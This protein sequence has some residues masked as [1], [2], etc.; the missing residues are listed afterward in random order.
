MG[1]VFVHGGKIAKRLIFVSKSDFEVAL[2]A[3]LFIGRVVDRVFRLLSHR[4]ARLGLLVVL[5]L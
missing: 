1:V 5:L 3:Y 2:S 4:L